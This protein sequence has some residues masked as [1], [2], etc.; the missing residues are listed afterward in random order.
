MVDGREACTVLQASRR[1]EINLKRSYRGST[2]EPA[3]N[4]ERRV[5]SPLCD[6]V[7]HKNNAVIED[8]IITQF[9]WELHPGGD[10]DLTRPC[11]PACSLYNSDHSFSRKELRESS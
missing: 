9:D 5:T 7:R 8:V 6:D 3:G 11:L 1:P 10:N 2:A 4:A